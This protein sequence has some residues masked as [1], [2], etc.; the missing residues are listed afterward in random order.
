MSDKDGQG[1]IV[2]ALDAALAACSAAVWADGRVIAQRFEAM[3]RGQSEALIPMLRGTMA[4]AGIAFADL[5]ALAATVGPGAYTGVRIGLAAA[6]G[7]ALAGGLPLLGVTT[8]DAVARAVRDAEGLDGS[9]LAVALE[10]KRADIYVQCFTCDLAL[11]GE[12]AVLAPEE[13]LLPDGPVA[14]A[15]DAADRLIAGLG[16]GARVRRVG[17]ARLD[18]PDAAIVAR[19]ACE[20]I[21]A[22]PGALNQPPPRPLYLRPPSVTLAPGRLRPS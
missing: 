8:F 9:N 5:D 15:G 10:T 14:V 16:D 1:V 17:N 3:A 18:Q 19:I 13:V 22:D 12:P 11:L 2:L 20:R 6:R 21:A 7:M 4:A